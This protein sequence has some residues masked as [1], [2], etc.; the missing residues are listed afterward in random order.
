MH[1]TVCY[2]MSPWV[3]VCHFMLFCITECHYISEYL[4]ISLSVAV[5]NYMPH[6]CMSLHAGH[7]VTIYNC[8]S[9]YFIFVTVCHNISLYFS[10]CHY[11]CVCGL[12][13]FIVGTRVSAPQ[14][15]NKPPSY[16][17]KC[18][19]N[20]SK[21]FLYMKIWEGEGSHRITITSSC[22]KINYK[23]LNELRNCLNI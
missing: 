16:K 10:I 21:I 20:I 5:C 23:H 1:D 18:Y 3:N 6:P 11:V 12:Y 7:Y 19:T 8:I 17:W 13:A 2:C 22:E 4:C 15:L 9:L 14:I